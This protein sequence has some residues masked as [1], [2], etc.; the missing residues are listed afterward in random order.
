[1][2]KV[3]V[4]GRAGGWSADAAPEKWKEL[5]TFVIEEQKRLRA[6]GVREEESEELR[7]EVI[8]QH[9]AALKALETAESGALMSWLTDGLDDDTPPPALRRSF[10]LSPAMLAEIT[11]AEINATVRDLMAPAAH[12]I[13]VVLPRRERLG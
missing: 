5:L 11:I 1:M 12:R 9:E 6:Y 4:A 8:T 10:E 7:R 2:G 3:L 13:V